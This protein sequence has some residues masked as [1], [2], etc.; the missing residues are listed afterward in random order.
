MAGWAWVWGDTVV[1]FTSIAEQAFRTD[2]AGRRVFA[3]SGPFARPYLVPDPGTEARLL[4][5][6]A[7][8][9]AVTFALTTPPLAAAVVTATAPARVDP[10]IFFPVLVGGQL[11]TLLVNRVFLGRELGRLPRAPDR[12]TWREVAGDL[13]VRHPAPTLRRGSVG[14]GVIALVGVY[15]A[16]TGS[17]G[18]GLACAALFAGLGVLW[19]YALTLRLKDDVV[20]QDDL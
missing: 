12:L 9:Y 18:V 17:A 15:L 16:A 20:E 1:F 4:R 7:W 3:P 11:V 8:A 10:A 6:M 19:A 5:R 14:F 13:A 2:A